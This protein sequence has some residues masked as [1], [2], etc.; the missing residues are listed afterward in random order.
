LYQKLQKLYIYICLILFGVRCAQI[1]PLSG[2]KKDITPPK[3]LSCSPE[4]TSLNFSSKTIE[5]QFDEYIILKD[6]ANQ[7]IITPQTKEAPEFL[8]QGKKLKISFNE[9]L[10]PNTTYKLAFGNAISD[11]NESNVLQNFEYIFS[12]GSSIDSLSIKGKV[13]SSEDKKPETQTLVGL[14]AAESSDSVIYKEKPLYICKTNSMGDFKFNY[15]PNR[16]FKIVAIKDQ[17]KNLQYDGSEERIAFQKE[18]LNPA[19]SIDILLSMFK[20][21]PTKSFIKKSFLADYGKVLIVYNKPQTDIDQVL[22][23]GIVLFNQNQLKDTLTVFYNNKFDTLNVFIVHHSQKTDTV[24]IKVLSESTL[25]KQLKDNTIKYTLQP[26]FSS[27]LAFFDLPAFK[28]NTPVDSKDIITDKIHVF[29]KTDTLTRTIPFKLV[30]DEKTI[31]Y[32]KIEAEF[33]PET[34]YIINF[35]KGCIYNDSRRINDS[36]TYKFKTTA[37]DD[38]AQLKIKLL[39][40]KKENYLVRLL[41]SKEQIVDERSVEF[42]LTSTSEKI[43]EYK[44]IVPGNYSIKIVEDANKN[45]LFDTGNYFFKTQ[46]ETIYIN[47]SSI[48]LLSG[49]EIENEWIVK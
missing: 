23:S 1:T 30:K 18:E 14:Y 15:L 27:I 20:E 37:L 41:N 49:W 38:Y 46:S 31:T 42:S 32:F 2:G 40:P 3:V 7:F 24:T 6:A 17:N 36:V 34:D 19:D 29:E 26:N 9:T 8:V 16:T 28:L 12:T 5:I 43:L 11:L 33:K 4:N 44:N 45:G 25:N 48:K 39:F 22:G 35:A 10:L 21:V 47:P 13:L